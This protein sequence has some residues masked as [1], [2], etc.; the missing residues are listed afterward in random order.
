MIRYVPLVGLLVFGTL[1]SSCGGGDSSTDP[2]PN[3]PS[4]PVPSSLT[5]SAGNQQQATGGTAVAV[6]PAVEVRDASGQPMSGVQVLFTVQ[7]GGGAITGGTP[8]TNS[9]GIAAVGSWTLGPNGTQRI[10]AQVGSLPPVTFQATIT[11]GTEQLVATFGPGGGKFEITDPGHAFQGLSLTVPSGAASGPAEW[12]F[13]TAPSAPTLSLPAGYRVSGPALEISTNQGR[14]SGLMTLEVPI[15]AGPNAGVVVVLVDPARGALE[16]LPMVARTATSARVMTQHLR[17]DLLLGSTPPAGAPPA[18]APPGGTFGT[19][20]VSGGAANLATL[21]T[22]EF[23]LPLT[24]G[25]GTLNR[26]PVREHGSDASP[27]G[28]GAAIAIVELVGSLK[29]AFPTF[30]QIVRPIDTPGG[31]QEAAPLATLQMINEQVTPG[32]VQALGTIRDALAQL[33]KAERDPLVHQQVTAAIGLTGSPAAVALPGMFPAGFKFATAT[34][35]SQDGLTLAT[36]A[37]DDPVVMGMLGVFQKVSVAVM[38]TATPDEVDEVLPV[39]SFVISFE[40]VRPLIQD[41]GGLASLAVASAQRSG[42]NN[43]LAD[44]MGHP[45]VLLEVEAVEGGGWLPVE[46]D[47]VIVRSAATRLRLAPGS[48]TSSF[49]LHGMDGVQVGSVAGEPME[50]A[51]IDAITGQAPLDPVPFAVVLFRQPLPGS[52]Q[53]Q[54]TAA[55]RRFVRAPFEISPTQ[56]ALEGGETSVEFEVSVPMPPAEGFRVHWDWG[57]GNTSENLGLTTATHDYDEPGNYKVTATL[58]DVTGGIDLAVDIAQ[59]TSGPGGWVG[60]VTYSL[61]T[62]IGPAS[63][64]VWRESKFHTTELRLEP[65]PKF[66]NG[67]QRYLVVSGETAF[68]GDSGGGECTTTGISEVRPVGTGYLDVIGTQ[69]LAYRAFGSMDPWQVTLEIQCPGQPPTYAHPE[70]TQWM[71][72]ERD[73]EG[74]LIWSISSDPNLLEGSAS[75]LVSPLG[76]STWDFTWRF[77]RVWD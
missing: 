74:T 47:D 14:A 57:D 37:E 36:Q 45:P 27:E 16:V 11:P 65:G 40:N 28:H 46:G 54:V 12:R 26:W 19:Q 30:V 22:I 8:S 68:S 72:T 4:I 17:A 13:R 7:E 24:P 50:L 21:L 55:V 53:R 60:E 39:S 64:G 6:A 32:A 62:R 61:M 48:A 49:S 59:V 51:G 75:L 29:Q 70:F 9:Q 44:R 23:D 73:E 10:Q 18:G 1:L 42:L 41:L 63:N 58:R 38:A 5:V 66:P 33:S 56:R 71:S 15:D 77:E 20:Q 35:G 67:T 52:S 2:T 25:A 69:V 43:F 34:A 31:Y 76:E 3:P